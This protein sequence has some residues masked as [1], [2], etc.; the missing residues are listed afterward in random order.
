[1]HLDIILPTLNRSA[2][3]RRAVSSVMNAEH[4]AALPFDIYIVDN[5]STDDT[6]RAADE[7]IAQWGPRVHYLQEREP[8]KSRALNAGIAATHGTLLGF[9]DDDEE[10]AR[11]W[12]QAV[13][14][15]FANPNVDFVGGPC[16]PVWPEQPPAWL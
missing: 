4:A 3:L 8:G 16:M 7:L 13:A 1:M 5:N 11:G 15:A 10:I 2:Q 12:M 14:R 6:A 9:L